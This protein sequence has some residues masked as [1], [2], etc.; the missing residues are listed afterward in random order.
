MEDLTSV[1]DYG[2][3]CMRIELACDYVKDTESCEEHKKSGL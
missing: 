1:T 2:N 3:S